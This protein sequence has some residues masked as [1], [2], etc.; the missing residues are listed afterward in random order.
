MLYSYNGNSYTVFQTITL[1]LFGQLL[2]RYLYLVQ[3]VVVTLSSYLLTI[4][5]LSDVAIRFFMLKQRG[6][7]VSNVGRN[8]TIFNYRTRFLFAIFMVYFLADIYY[9]LI[10]TTNL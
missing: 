5:V 1:G 9:A 10:S 6:I 4:E 8:E 2:L 3:R 7:N